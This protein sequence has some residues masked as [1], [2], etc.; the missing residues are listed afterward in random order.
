MLYDAAIIG[1][2]P[3]GS[4]AAYHL[5]RAGASV[6]MIEKGSQPRYK[7]CGGG[8]V[9][10]GVEQL[11]VPL[12]G[13]VQRACTRVDLHLNATGMQFSTERSVPVITMTM[14]HDLD[15][16]L[17][18]AA[19]DIGAHCKTNC[20]VRTIRQEEAGVRLETTEG[21]MRAKFLIAADGAGSST[22]R[23]CGWT[24]PHH[25]TPALEYEVTVDGRTFERFSHSARFDADLVPRG[26]GWVFPKAKHL[27]IGVLTTRRHAVNLNESIARYLR[28]LD[29]D[30]NCRMEKHGFMIPHRP[31]KDPLARKR[32]FLVGDAAGVVDPVAGEGISFAM[33]SGR[34]AA[35]SLIESGFAEPQ[36]AGS[37]VK[38]MDGEILTEI[39]YGAVIAR[40][41]Y[42]WPRLRNRV[43]RN[44]GQGLAEAIADVMMG[45]KTYRQMFHKL[46]NY[47][48]LVL[49]Q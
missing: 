37:F 14:R 27:S 13:A 35:E 9:G 41:F 26:Y 21:E 1:S 20:E 6:L 36:A 15:F 18:S 38:K 49:P 3:A 7:T 48:K 5:A 23:K 33:W 42:D 40:L 39:R 29:I 10:R 25:C 19:K 22:A 47:V 34:L 16:L 45:K 2:G 28:F 17:F 12:N 32:V 11:V 30:E 46:K 31:R 24:A 44:T 4:T 43:F 8:L